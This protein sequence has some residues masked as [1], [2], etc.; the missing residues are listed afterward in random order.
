MTYE[1]GESVFVPTP[2]NDVRLREAEIDLLNEDQGTVRVIIKRT[3]K[4]EWFTRAQLE[5]ANS[6][7]YHLTLPAA[8]AGTAR[9]TRT[10]VP[11]REMTAEEKRIAQDLSRCSMGHFS[12]DK[13]FVRE[14][15]ALAKHDDAQ[16]TDG[17]GRYL[18]ALRHKYR[19]QI[20][21]RP[22]QGG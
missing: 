19:M 8:A 12:K 1:R 9:K 20:G 6:S 18:Q 10:P 17:Q 21:I 5:H 2:G 4:R 13:G 16:I 7:T 22:E 3:G 11:R 15:V 14:M